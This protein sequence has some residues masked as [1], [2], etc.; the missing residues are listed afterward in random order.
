MLANFLLSPPGLLK[1]NNVD[2]FFPSWLAKA[3]NDLYVT[4]LNDVISDPVPV[5]ESPVSDPTLEKEPQVPD[6][7]DFP[8]SLE[9]LAN[10]RIHLNRLLGLSNLYYID[11]DDRE[12]TQELISVRRSIAYLINDAPE[13]TLESLWS[14]E[15][16]ERYWALVRSGIQSE[17][18]APVDSSIRD[19][20]VSKLSPDHN[21]GF[22][23]PGSINAFLVCMIYF[24]PGTLTVPDAQSKI[25]SWLYPQYDA[26]YGNPN[27]SLEHPYC[28]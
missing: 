20:A 17:P 21:G 22:G 24:A 13:N 15:L 26:I 27:V 28:P 3:Y 16:G 5:T 18:L 14:T 6:F 4:D 9:S 1:I 12:I 10:N 19:A 23:Q 25:P 2:S 11:P 7:G 8:D